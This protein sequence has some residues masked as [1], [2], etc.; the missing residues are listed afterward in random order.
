VR[1]IDGSNVL[2]ISYTGPDPD[3]SANVADTVR[4]AY[5]DQAVAF[6][7]DD[8]VTNANFFRKQTEQIRQQLRDAEKRKSDFEKANGIILD[9]ANNDPEAARLA[10]LAGAV[11]VAAA[12]FAPQVNP[13]AAQLAQ[14]DAAIASA[15]RVL[16]P[17]NPDLLNMRRQRAAIAQSAQSASVMS[18]PAAGPSITSLLG[19]QQ[20]KVLAQRGKIEEAR[21]LAT[22]VKVFREQYEKATVRVSELQ[23]QSESGDSGFTLLGNATAP[24]SPDFPKWPLLIFGS[25]A[26]GGALG[27]L[28]AL[29]LELISR[30]VRGT[31]DLRF[32]KVPMLGM[33]TVTPAEVPG[34][35]PWRFFRRQTL[36]SEGA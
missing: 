24:S 23:Q 35:R 21:Q 19:A 17:N 11:P 14:A 15:E 26:L 33:M 10:A 4:K 20:A 9:D 22:D 12:Q 36:Q 31:E 27:V 34:R 29:A 13:M 28:L 2:E 8:A 16:G 7:R 25:L 32:D 18:G 5:V 30:R 1:P 3:V 6:K